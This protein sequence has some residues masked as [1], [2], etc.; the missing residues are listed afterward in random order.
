[1]RLQVVHDI[2]MLGAHVFRFR[3]VGVEAEEGAPLAREI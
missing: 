3:P 1:L 2:R